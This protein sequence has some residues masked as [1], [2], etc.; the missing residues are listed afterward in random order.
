MHRREPEGQPGRR[1]GKR[2]GAD[3]PLREEL[4]LCRQFG[5]SHSHFTG[6]KRRWTDVDRAKALAYERYLTERCKDCGTA[7][8]DWFDD[9]G[10][11]L[12]EPV[13]EAAIKVC[14][15]CIAVARAR[16]AIPEGATGA[17]VT[18]LPL[19]TSEVLTPDDDEVEDP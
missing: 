7:R 13:W 12:E 1:S 10:Y 4:A 15:G 8:D 18:M 16:A 17:Y 9:D 19:G 11:M 2:V 3:G 5:I 6:G 14:D